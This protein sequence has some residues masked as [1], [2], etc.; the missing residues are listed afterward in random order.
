M[1][2][3]GCLAKF[4]N[5]NRAANIA[6]A[7]ELLV[8]R[9]LATRKRPRDLSM[10]IGHIRPM[11]LKDSIAAARIAEELTRVSVSLT[12]LTFVG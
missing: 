6:R 2:R 8:A 12:N 7:R 10:S 5:G 3:F 1:D 11:W 9:P 4:T